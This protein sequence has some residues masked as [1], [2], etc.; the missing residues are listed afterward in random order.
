MEAVGQLTGG[1]A[2]DF[3]NM[4]TV[5]LGATESLKATLP[6]D[7]SAQHR[8]ADL[9][10]QAATQAAALTHRLLA[11]SRPQPADPKPTNLNALIG[12]LID[13]LRRTIGESV[14]LKTDLTAGL[15][16]VLVDANQ[17]ENAILNLAVNARD[18]MAR[19]GAA[20]DWQRGR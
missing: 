16:A 19:G 18:A 5:V 4:L 13:M 14:A 9:V 8:R 20:S 17:L 2:H 15:P 7:A 3:N 11:F 1:I 10:M 12:G 6:R